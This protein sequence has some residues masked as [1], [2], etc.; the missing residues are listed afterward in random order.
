MRLIDCVHKTPAARESGYPY[1]AIPQMKSGRLDFE[2]ARRISREDFL[3][4][5]KKARPQPHD[6]VLSRRTNPGATAI[7]RTGTEFALGQN[8]VLLRAD[9]GRVK[10]AFLKWLVRGPAWW[11]EIGKYL[12]V[13]A[14]FDSLRCADVPNFELQIPPL[15]VQ[16]RI[17]DLLDALD[18]RIELN[19][20]M[21]ETLEAMARA[22]FKSW[23]VDFEPVRAK[24][25]GQNTGL[26]SVIAD[27]FPDRLDANGLPHGWHRPQLGQLLTVLETG[28]RPRGGVAN[29]REG[30][31]SVGAESIT[32]VGHFDF[33]KTKYVQKEYYDSMSKG[34]VLDGDVLIYKD[35]GKPGELRPAITYVSGGFPFPRFCI[36]EH[37]FR[38]RTDAFS[39]PVLYMA[40]STDDAFWQMKELATGVAQPGLNQSAVRSLRITVPTD[41]VLMRHAGALIDPLLDR[42][43]RNSIDGH[44]L[45]SVRDLLL[46]KLISGELRVPDAERIAAAVICPSSMP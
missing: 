4:W 30:I 26:P 10:P 33:S 46:P 45:A 21:N 15:A 34:R 39:Q 43:N 5:T 11:R 6:V 31:P 35:G 19:R 36:N 32:R 16:H 23:F 20:R 42:C 18:D 2:T 24:E 1:I 9:G 41:G 44:K 7:D 40:L 28:R 38:V 13:G 8:L 14:L 12:N 3:D 29:I 25:A 17:G 27:R 37:V 22:L